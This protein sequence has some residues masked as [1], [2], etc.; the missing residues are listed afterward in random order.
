MNEWTWRYPSFS[1]VCVCGGEHLCI[2]VVVRHCSQSW[3]SNHR[4]RPPSLWS[5]VIAARSRRRHPSISIIIILSLCGHC[6]VL[7]SSPKVATGWFV[8]IRKEKEGAGRMY[9]VMC[10]PALLL[11]RCHLDVLTCHVIFSMCAGARLVGTAGDMALAH[12]CH[13]GCCV[14]RWVWAVDDGSGWWWPYAMWRGSSKGSPHGGCDVAWLGWCWASSAWSG[15]Q[16]VG[17]N[18][19]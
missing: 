19:V 10:W 8:A 14:P 18:I 16:C 3:S 9:D 6:C 12:W 1:F 4:H 13:R 11:R 2:P 7:S 17:L 15:S 5:S